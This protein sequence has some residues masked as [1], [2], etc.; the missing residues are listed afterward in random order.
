MDGCEITGKFLFQNT[1]NLDAPGTSVRFYLSED[2]SFAEGK[3]PLLMEV[4]TTPIEGAGNQVI[5]LDSRL[6]RD[7][8]LRRKYII[9]IIDPGNTVVESDKR[10]NCVLGPID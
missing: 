9:A 6:G 10:N 1:G 8:D 7:Q 4:T 3:N 5:G 2:G